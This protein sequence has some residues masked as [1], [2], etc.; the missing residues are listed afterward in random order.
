MADIVD[1]AQVQEAQWRELS[2]KHRPQQ[3]DGYVVDTDTPR[4]CEDCDEQIPPERVK[5]A[6]YCVRCVECQERF[7]KWNR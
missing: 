2:L 7:E 3:G 5:A 4:Y 6:P 1:M